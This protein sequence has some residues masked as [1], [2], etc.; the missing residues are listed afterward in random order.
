MEESQPKHSDAESSGESDRSLQAFD[1]TIRFS[2]AVILRHKGTH[3]LH[4]GCGDEHDKSTDLLGNADAR[5]SDEPQCID[6]GE[7]DKKGEADQKILQ[8]DRCTEAH[9]PA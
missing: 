4:K 2:R 9:D 3:S 5:R 7:Y 1:G 8:R 6:D